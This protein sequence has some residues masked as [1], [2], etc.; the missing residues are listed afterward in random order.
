MMPSYNSGTTGVSNGH[1]KLVYDRTS[2]TVLLQVSV[3]CLLLFNSMYRKVQ[4]HI[5]PIS[6]EISEVIKQ[7][8]TNI[9]KTE[10]ST[11]THTEQMA[12]E[13]DR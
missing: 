3:R 12:A 2:L 1:K 4:I 11:Y 6:I 10:K 9:I 7:T 5:K 8:S 13:E